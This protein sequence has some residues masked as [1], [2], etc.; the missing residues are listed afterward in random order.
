MKKKLLTQFSRVGRIAMRG[1]I[2][3]LIFVNILWAATNSEAQDVKSVNDIKI[4]LKLSN[5]S[6]DK[7]FRQIEH[8]TGF[9]FSY[10][11]EDIPS[12]FRFDINQQNIAVGKVLI[13]I[14]RDAALKFKQV[15]RNIS[16]TKLDYKEKPGKVE[17][18]IQTRDVS[19]KVTSDEDQEGLP[20]VN[21][22][23]KGTSNGTVTNVEGEY[24]LTVSE[25]ATLVFS[26]V[27]FTTEEVM[28]GNRSV[29]D[30]EM[31]QDIQ[32]LQELVVVGYGSLEKRDLTG[33]V[34][35]VD[36][37]ELEEIPNVS[38][39]QALQG[40]VP[41]LNVGAVDNAGE[42]PVI[43][44]RGQTTLS[45][46]SGDNQPL[47]V[48]DG[49]IY[50]G[51]LVDL[52][53][54]DIESIEVLKDASSAAIYGSQA[55][56][57]VVLVTTKKGLQDQKPII[58]YSGQ[59]AVQTPSN[60]LEPMNGAEYETFLTDALWVESRLAPDYIQPNPDFSLNP[61]FKTLGITQGY[62]NGLDNDWWD[63][64]T[65]NGHINSHTLS[66]RGRSNTVGYYIS[67]GY[68]DQEGFLIN[69]N[70]NRYNVR[71]NVDADITEWLN[72]GVE[73]FM[74][75]SDYSGVS[76]SLTSAFHT[77]P[78]APIY[79]DNGNYELQPDGLLLNPFL[80]IQNDDSDKRFNLF[81]TFHADI[82][83]PFIEGFNYR[84]N[85]SHNYRT[86]N[87]DRFE[88]YGANFTGFGYKNDYMFY[89]WTLDNIFS[90]KKTFA[91][92][93]RVDATLLYGVEKRQFKT[94]EVSAQN[95]I[96][97]V[98]GFNK[99][100]AGDPSLY[101]V[102]TGLEEEASLYTMGRLLYSFK[103]R[104]MITG[105][106]RRDGFSGFGTN[107][108]IG[109][110]PSMALGWIISDENFFKNS[111]GWMD[112]LKLRGSYGTTA[113]RGLSRYQTL[114]RMNLAPSRVF[115]DG[116]S[117]TFGQWISSMA[118]NELGW[119]TTTGIN[120]GFDFE[121]LDSRIS[122]N[123]E[124]YQNNTNDILYNIQIPN[125]TGFSVVPTNIGE[126][127]N[128]GL[129]FV[130]TGQI[131]RSSDFNWETSLNF[132]RNRNQ[133]ESILGADNN[134][135]GV[136]DDLINNQLFIGEPQNV[137]FDYKITGIWQLNEEDAMPNGFLPGTYKIE[138]FNNDGS[139]TPDDRQIIG[140]E[141]P[142]YRFGIS[143][144]LNYREVSLYFFIN[145]IQGGQDFYYGNSAPHRGNLNKQDQ[146]T[147]SNAFNFADGSTFNYWMPENPNAEFRRLDTPS[148]FAPSTYAQRNFIRLQD[149][150][151]AYNFNSD[152][153]EN[154]NIR[155]LKVFLSG[156]NLITLT[157]WKGWD[158]ETG[159][160]L[161][162][163]VPV[164]RSY[165]LGVNFEL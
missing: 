45:S 121:V 113:R 143:N 114:S 108:K 132:A 120:L 157:K 3:Q 137:I 96:N 98:L 19:G 61:Y 138:D 149:V 100:E 165:N 75:S 7:V 12:D 111:I 32:E 4:D 146:I 83:L 11:R 104:Y 78:Y 80:T 88:P 14:S 84:V 141:D 136:E 1:I 117:T 102:D 124:Y 126:V 156:K 21:V 67:G 48:V 44:V 52:N 66:V 133:I 64:L 82:K 139:F 18:L 74:T 128:H 26:S 130:L 99:L 151:V 97:P 2:V 105:T 25:G 119:E 65:S 57:G 35:S 63:L 159:V 50:R 51:N 6:L 145:S 86:N 42:D 24:R 46:S 33:A 161:V 34:A 106:I 43:S 56:N 107:D 40:S 69:D 60:R 147:Y 68:T 115:G 73:S 125:I 91:Q 158:P 9:V 76:P 54:A 22:V 135:D 8:Q 110:F 127:S 71:L 152:F 10:N 103:N 53:T 131:L 155:N 13:E 140:Y 70:Y 144:R 62:A 55:S 30:L 93:H 36:I 5:A 28:V 116:G 17:V 39:L 15:N 77:Q 29:I 37:E 148:N 47:I 150:S 122:G 89:D 164:M 81:G 41:G 20:G 23:E 95:F 154:Y 109:I 72:V 90:Y 79:D 142:S 58:N 38:L 160:G 101:S 59:Y 87:Q 85:Y 112:Y 16:V 123:F 49:I 92:D 94:T 163:G 153:L 134:G 31:M 162:P 129:E 118:N 27:G